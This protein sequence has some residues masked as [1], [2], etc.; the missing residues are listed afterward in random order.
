MR[1]G[2]KRADRYEPEINPSYEKLAQHYGT[3]VMLARAR[4]PR[5]KAK[6]EVAVLVAQRWILAALRHRTVY[7]VAELKAA[8]G[9]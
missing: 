7:S 4:K 5:D 3:C 6:G 8:I 1:S 9:S 2:V